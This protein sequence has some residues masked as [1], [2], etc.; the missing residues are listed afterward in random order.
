M[1]RRGNKRQMRRTSEMAKFRAAEGKE[2][3]RDILELVENLNNSRWVWEKVYEIGD[4]RRVQ[5]IVC[6]DGRREW[7]AGY[8]I[9]KNGEMTDLVIIEDIE[10]EI[11]EEEGE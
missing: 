8:E 5:L 2:R 10:E 9:D 11:E 3:D 1:R 6:N 4:E 7:W